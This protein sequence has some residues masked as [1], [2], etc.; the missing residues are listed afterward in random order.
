M[1]F[2]RGEWRPTV[3]QC[4]YQLRGDGNTGSVQASQSLVTRGKK[5]D[6]SFIA[7]ATQQVELLEQSP[8][9]VELLISQGHSSVCACTDIPA[10]GEVATSTVVVLCRS[11]G[12][13]KS[14]G[15]NALE[16]HLGM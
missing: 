9:R 6:I 15:S 4:L 14:Q 1:V 5:S 2:S 10:G 11:N 16:T 12:S 7:D 8:E 3:D 13:C